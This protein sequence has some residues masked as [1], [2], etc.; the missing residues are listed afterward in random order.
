MLHGAADRPDDGGLAAM[1]VQMARNFEARLRDAGKPVQ[2]V[3]HKGDR[4]NSIFA[5]L[6]QRHD[7]AQ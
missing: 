2:A 3:Y 5:S 6:T 1:H 7:E 4:R